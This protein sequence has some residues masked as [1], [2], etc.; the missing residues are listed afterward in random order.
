MGTINGRLGLR[1]STRKRTATAKS[2]VLLVGPEP[3]G[4]VPG[5]ACPACA[6]HHVIQY[7]LRGVLTRMCGYCGHTWP[8]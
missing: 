8:L 4:I 3:Q 2:R 7:Y 1:P 5:Q 6:C